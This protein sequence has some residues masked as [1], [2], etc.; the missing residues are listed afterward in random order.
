MSMKRKAA[1]WL[2]IVL[3][4]GNFSTYA[5]AE[6]VAGETG[7]SSEAETEVEKESLTHFDKLTDETILGTWEGKYGGTADG[8][9]VSRRIKLMIPESSGGNFCGRAIVDGG[10]NGSYY[11]TGTFDEEGNIQFSGADWYYNPSNFSF[12]QFSGKFVKSQLGLSGASDV[13]GSTSSFNIRKT[14][15]QYYPLK[16]DLDNIP[17]SWTGEYDGSNGDEVVRRTIDIEF[18]DVS[19]TQISGKVDISPSDKANPEDS[20]YGS[21]YFS[22]G[23]DPEEG[24]VY[25]FQGTEFIWY[26]VRATD[27]SSEVENFYFIA[28]YG[29]LDAANEKIEGSSFDDVGSTYNW[30]IWNMT[31]VKDKVEDFKA[32]KDSIDT[33]E[34][35]NVLG[36]GKYFDDRTSYIHW[37]ILKKEDTKVLMLCDSLVAVMPFNTDYTDVDWEHSSVR[38][39]LND[40]FY[41]SAFTETQQAMIISTENDNAKNSNY[42]SKDASGTE[43]KVFLL[44]EEE[45][46]QY[47]E[48]GDA[49]TVT[50]DPD[51][52]IDAIGNV[53][54]NNVLWMTRTS[55]ASGSLVT[56][57]DADG[58]LNYEGIPVSTA[59]GVRPAI[60]VDLG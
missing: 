18:T 52:N 37:T 27:Q 17:M 15:D 5:S 10:E 46:K 41:N 56:Y 30:G 53:N 40:T 33:L 28:L 43:D 60:W 36:F 55:G 35:G 57:V 3:A 32:S 45:Y 11:F 47:L 8:E 48:N 1:L 58:R 50:V 16:V 39:W 25:D 42:G 29:F 6:E 26:P 38:E 34:P 12:A 54:T 23:F 19:D 49:A 4:A 22:A 14:S 13:S 9:I 44:S 31:A 20:V 2:S 21:Y 59:I 51:D 24:R 7:Y